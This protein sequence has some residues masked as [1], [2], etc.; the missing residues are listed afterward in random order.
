MSGGVRVVMAPGPHSGP[1]QTIS[2]GASHF[3]GRGG[4]DL[5]FGW[6][7]ALAA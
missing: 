2:L 3:A 5:R 1:D 7:V 6:A 4:R